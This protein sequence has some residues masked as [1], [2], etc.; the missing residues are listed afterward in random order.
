MT[1]GYFPGQY[2]SWNTVIIA[3]KFYWAA[4]VWKSFSVK[5]QI[6]F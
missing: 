3:R 6:A 1:S 2:R 4:L 5:G